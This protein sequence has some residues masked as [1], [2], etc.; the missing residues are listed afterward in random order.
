MGFFRAASPLDPDK[1]EARDTNGYQSHVGREGITVG[2][3]GLIISFSKHMTKTT[4]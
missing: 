3:A 2:Q 4:V 1:G